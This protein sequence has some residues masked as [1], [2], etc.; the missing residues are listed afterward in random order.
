MS[1]APGVVSGKS[2][3]SNLAHPSIKII[4]HEPLIPAPPD[5]AE[6]LSSPSDDCQARS[7]VHKRYRSERTA[8]QKSAAASGTSQ[9]SPSRHS[10]RSESSSAS[11]SSSSSSESSSSSGSDSNSESSSSSTSSSSSAASSSSSASSRNE[12]VRKKRARLTGG[13]PSREVIASS[14]A[15]VQ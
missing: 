6:R 14:A 4:P 3:S 9:T 13:E 11:D 5:V 2:E 8:E 1:Q 15:Q 12:H 10:S 7:H